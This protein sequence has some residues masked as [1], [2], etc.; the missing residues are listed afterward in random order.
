M[1]RLFSSS[2]VATAAYA[3]T[4]LAGQPSVSAMAPG[5]V[6]APP[7]S[8]ATEAL[9]DGDDVRA[10]GIAAMQSDQVQHT[11]S[12]FTLS[13]ATAALADGDDVRARTL[14]ALQH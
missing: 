9:R 14:A 8:P 7:L 4:L 3:F 13:P 6:L 10:R 11:A 12:L 5:G 2:V 1:N